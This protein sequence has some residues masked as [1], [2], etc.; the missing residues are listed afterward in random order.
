MGTHINIVEIGPRDGFQ[1]VKEFM[2]T[3]F[4]LEIIDG[5]VKSGIKRIQCTS[6]VSPKAIPQM[7]DAAVVAKTV[8]G[9]YPQTSFFALVPNFR[10]AESAV[11]NG[12]K[13]VSVVVSLS[14]SHN[15]ANINRTHEQ[16]IEE[17]KK[18]RGEF[19]DLKITVDAATVFGCPFEGRMEIPPLIELLG[20]LHDVGIRA[21]TLCDT[22][23]V[24]YPAQ[25]RAILESSKKAFPDSIFNLHIH[26]TRNMGII[27]SYEGIK[28][29]AQSVETSLGGLGGCPF[30]PGASGNT[31]TEDFVYMMNREGYET[32]ID[33][34]IVLETARKL[35]E[36]AA[37][38]YSGHHIN[39]DKVHQDFT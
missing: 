31:S 34:S 1:S 24:A 11:E 30:A 17:I 36:K 20:K 25:I 12:V 18:I 23:G 21:F 35:R 27:N 19:P 22:I 14:E 4:K 38:L 3:E 16:S 2:P 29:G 13:D 9:K 15:K 32:G 10:G 5:L 28:C 8:I 6:F 7:Q 26:D 37:G 39:I 33:F